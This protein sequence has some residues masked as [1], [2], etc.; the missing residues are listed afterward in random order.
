[1][2]PS[3]RS[4]PRPVRL[5][6]LLQVF[7]T[8]ACLGTETFCNYVLKLPRVYTFPLWP[9]R[10]RFADLTLYRARFNFFHSSAFFTQP[11]WHY[12]YPAPLSLIYK[13]FYS[14]PH[15]G[16]LFIAFTIAWLLLVSFLLHRALVARGISAIASVSILLVLIFCSYALFFELRQANLEFAVWIIISCGL[17]A[18]YGE[19][20]RTAAA[21]FGIATAMKL[22]PF[23]FLGLF[24]SR[25]QY[26]QAFLSLGV[27]GLTTIVS[28]WALCP[29]LP[30]SW[31]GIGDGLAA[32]R[33]SYVLHIPAIPFDHSLF[34]LL[35][36]CLSFNPSSEA[37]ASSTAT[38]ALILTAYLGVCA[39]AG[40]TLYLV[41]IRKLPLANQVLCL[42]VASILLPPVSFDYTLIHLY[43]PL[44]LLLFATLDQPSE[45]ARQF[46]P[47]LR[48]ALVL[49]AI[50]LAPETELIFREITLEGQLKACCL[51]ILFFIGLCCP[52]GSD[53]GIE[54][55]AADRA[56]NSWFPRRTYGAECGGNTPKVAQIAT[57]QS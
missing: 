52:F 7:I 43:A 56:K 17:W 33:T 2:R 29:N 22:F 55:G 45:C 8:A 18:F 35:R 3:S 25:R 51:M 50:L 42:T 48:P 26:R 27:A 13:F 6:L 44:V 47:G 32:F 12:M 9:D 41:R 30:D 19:R 14:F 37:A 10:N 28:L 46:K 39:A 49:I 5:L 15:A 40:V 23:V 36:W 31:R 24:L 53:A 57:R 54:S 4:L 21:C 11:G 34:A 38:L 16:Q 20:F 1:M